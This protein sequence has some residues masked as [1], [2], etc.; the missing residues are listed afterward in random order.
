MKAH[1][2]NL[3]RYSKQPDIESRPHS[4][5]RKKRDI[6]EVEVSSSDESLP[7]Q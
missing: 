1:D 4:S 7:L 2:E 5:Q 3:I 6:E